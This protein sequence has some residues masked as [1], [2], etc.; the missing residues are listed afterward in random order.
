MRLGKYIGLQVHQP[1]LTV[2]EE[3]IDNVL[4]REQRRNAVIV[5]ID[6]GENIRKIL[7]SQPIDDDFALDF[8]DFDSLEEW[9]GFIR[10][11]LEER[12]RISAEEKVERELLDQ[13][14]ADSDI[15]VDEEDVRELAEALY[16]DILDDL[17]E[18]GV[19]LETYLK[20]RRMTA[21]ALQEEQKEEALL[22][23]QSE[24]V[25]R[26]VAER[27]GITVLPNEVAD[28]VRAMAEEDGEDPAE[29]ADSFEDEELMLIQDDLL[30]GKAMDFLMEKA[31]W[32]E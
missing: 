15:P 9:R 28:E 13:I 18:S 12:R 7:E 4:L 27:E 31:V 14:I 6:E 23:L 10:E 19:S 11:I 25:L 16:L 2:R 29:Y 22:A 3:E 20:R 30:L 32:E 1:D 17:S 21:E 24:A 8:S 5:H 26:T